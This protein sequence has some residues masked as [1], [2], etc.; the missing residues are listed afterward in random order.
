[1]AQCPTCGRETEPGANF[2]PT[3][4]ASLVSPAVAAMI[5]DAHKVLGQKPEDAFA[6]YNLAIAYKLAGQDELAIEQFAKVAESQPDYA[7]AFYEMGAL[8]A[9]HN[10]RPEAVAALTRAYE[11]E[12]ENARVRRLLERLVDS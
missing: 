4:G 1:M 2:C 3:C 5:Q 12:P 11:L 8:Y 10:R 7:D 6:R 9:K